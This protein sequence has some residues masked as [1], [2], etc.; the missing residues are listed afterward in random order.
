MTTEDSAETAIPESRQPL[1][2]PQGVTEADWQREMGRWQ[3]PRIRALLGCIRVLRDVLESN[4]AI[5]HCSPTRIREMEATVRKVAAA[6][7]GE[8]SA[9]LDGP[10]LIPELDASRQA[11]RANL[12]HIDQ[13]LL[14]EL[15]S[16]PTDLPEEQYDNL[17]RFLC[18]AI[19]EINGFLQDSYGALLAS[20]PRSEH[21]ADYYLSK[22]FPRDVEEAEW[23]HDSVVRFESTQKAYESDRENVLVE[24]L[25]RLSREERIPSRAEWADVG[26]FLE[27]L[28]SDFTPKL[29]DVIALKGIRL[30]ELELL[31]Q[32]ATEIPTVSRIATELFESS[33]GALS[34]LEVVM[35]ATS[36]GDPQE[37]TALKSLHALLCERIHPQLQSLDE[38]LRD[39]GIFIPVWLAGISYRRALLLRPADDRD[40]G[41]PAP[42]ADP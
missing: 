41:G 9:L 25:R 1:N 38:Y 37:S 5:L 28:V 16:Y 7:R 17:R 10:S 32:Y 20:D 13:T 19:G 34:D 42:S 3:N 35:S 8:V 15:D 22:Q 36:E 31:G 4:F 11:V 26:A 21:G 6:L 14:K 27:R 24:A 18:V 12:G 23:L 2:L 33:L 39:L 30:E 29:R 40:L